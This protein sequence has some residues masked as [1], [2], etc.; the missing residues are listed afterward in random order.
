MKNAWKDR[1]TD[2]ETM[3]SDLNSKR[4]LIFDQINQ[5]EEENS[6]DN[7]GNWFYNLDFKNYNTKA[8]LRDVESIIIFN[9]R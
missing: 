6:I 1:F 3:Y 2:K 7:I 5:S 8:S 4:K 9:F